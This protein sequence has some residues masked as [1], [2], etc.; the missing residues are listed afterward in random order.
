MVIITLIIFVVKTS[1][2][3]KTAEPLIW[4]DTKTRTAVDL[5][6]IQCMYTEIPCE[7]PRCHLAPYKQRF[8]VVWMETNVGRTAQLMA[9][10]RGCHRPDSGHSFLSAYLY[11]HIITCHI[12]VDLI[13]N[14]MAFYHSKNFMAFPAAYGSSYARDWICEAAVTYATTVAVLNTLTH[15][16]GSRIEPA[17]LQQPE[18]LQSDS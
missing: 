2:H 10:R 9:H 5:G 11:G 3:S 6:Y 8:S 7:G 14:F 18:P 1:W 13:W 4:S 17:P 15:C 12:D 16:T